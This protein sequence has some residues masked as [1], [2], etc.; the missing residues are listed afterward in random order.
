MNDDHEDDSLRIVR[1]FIDPNATSAWMTS[2]DTAGG[3]WRYENDTGE[4]EGTIAWPDGPIDERPQIRQAVVRL[5]E[6]A[7][8]R[9][10]LPIRPH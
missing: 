7:S 10:G 4:Q 6:E 9:L 1:A 5:Y 2:L 8:G 3:T